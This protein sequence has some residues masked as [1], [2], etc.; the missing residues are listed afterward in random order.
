MYKVLRILSKKTLHIQDDIEA[1]L[2]ET[3]ATNPGM[4]VVDVS[5]LSPDMAFVTVV[6]DEPKVSLKK[7]AKGAKPSPGE[8]L[9]DES[10]PN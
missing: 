7:H 9:L 10:K 8:N 2:N 5:I 4:Q 1:A 3:L 6:V